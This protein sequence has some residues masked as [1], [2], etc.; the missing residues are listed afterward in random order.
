VNKRE[1]RKIAL[2]Y[3]ISQLADSAWDSFAIEEVAASKNFDKDLEC[4][5]KALRAL[6][7]SLEN[8]RDKFKD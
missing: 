5:T 3:A 4:L 8:R 2:E 6:R 7:A 1:A